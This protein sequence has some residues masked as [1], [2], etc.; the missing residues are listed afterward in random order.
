MPKDYKY[1]DSTPV[2]EPVRKGK[3]KAQE[4]GSGIKVDKDDE[5][6]Y[7]TGRK[8][9]GVA[10]AP[11]TSISAA[12]I[13]GSQPD[14]PVYDS[15]KFGAKLSLAKNKKEENEA[16]KELE[17]AVKLRQSQQ[18]KSNTGET[19]NPMGDAYKKGGTASSRAD[20]IAQRGKTRG[21][22]IMCGGGK[23]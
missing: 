8:A 21:K 6:E 4:P 12:T 23:V 1:S 19:T 13:L 14:F 15:A 18:R 16:S 11:A 7:S 20:G 5:K 22:I 17:S 3:V 10:M 2:D 9:L